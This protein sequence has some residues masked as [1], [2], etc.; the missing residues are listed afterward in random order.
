MYPLDLRCEL[1]SNRIEE[2]HVI[3]TD[4]YRAFALRNGPFYSKDFVLKEKSSGKLL[5]RGLDYELVYFFDDIAKLTPGLEIVG[6]VVVH[7]TKVATDLVSVANYVGGPFAHSAEAIDKAITDLELNNRNTHWKFVIEKPDLFQPSPHMHDFGDVFGME[8]LISILA[9][10]RDTLMVGNNKQLE[11]IREAV[12]EMIDALIQR[13]KEHEENKENPHEV[14]AEQVNCYDKEAIDSMM[15]DISKRFDDIELDL[16]NVWDVIREIINRI[17]GI[18]EA[19]AGLAERV[20]GVEESLSRLHNQIAEINDRLKD[21]EK[22]IDDILKEIQAL[23]DKNASQDE[24]INN[25]KKAIE[26][27]QQENEE[28][29][30]AIEQLRNDMNQ[31]DTE[32]DEALTDLDNRLDQIEAGDSDNVKW[33][34]VNQNSNDYSQIV[35]KLPM[36]QANGV[37]EIAKYLDFNDVGG[38]S[39]YASRLYVSSGIL[40]CTGKMSMV[41][42]QIRSDIRYKANREEITP[43]FANEVIQKIGPAFTYTMKKGGEKTAGMIAQQFEKHFPRAVEYVYDEDEGFDRLNLKPSVVTS[44]LYSGYLFQANYAK[45]LEKRIERLEKALGIIEEE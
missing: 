25:N 3:G 31:K 23:K 34:N 11:Q 15:E 21:I 12:S 27:L 22:A 28:Q 1:T 17:E 32:H 5:K 26:D 41:D 24:E 16:S 9:H 2:S 39:D 33:E 44:L 35:G 13:I 4:Q 38:T 7:N 20:S 14:T 45:Q 10:I 36:V 40:Y 42:N 37:L 29:D 18:E 6:V 19:I 43:E 30:T 8:Y